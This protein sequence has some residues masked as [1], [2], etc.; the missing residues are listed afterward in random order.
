MSALPKDREAYWSDPSNRDQVGLL[1][2]LKPY[3]SDEMSI[4]EVD[5]KTLRQPNTRE[6]AFFDRAPFWE[7]A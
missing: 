5:P 4:S 3:P 7:R 2:I 1:S 6:A